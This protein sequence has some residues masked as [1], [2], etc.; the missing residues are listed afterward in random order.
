MAR[1]GVIVRLMENALLTV[2]SLSAIIVLG[3][4]MAR[5]FTLPTGFTD[6]ISK[7]VFNI[8]VP[9]AIFYAFAQAEFDPSLLMLV[10]LGFVCCF[11]PWFVAT[12]VSWREEY[13]RRVLLMTNISGYNIGNF[14]L[15]FAQ[16]FFPS[17]TIVALCLFDAGNSI[18]I[19]GGIYPFSSVILEKGKS[20]NERM[21]LALK[22][23]F[24]SVPFDLY[25]VLVILAA[26][27][28]TIPYQLV[29]LVE[30]FAH[31]NAFLAMF[32]IG[33]MV[34]FSIDLNKLGQLVRLVGLRLILSTILSATVFFLLPFDLT[35]RIVIASLLWAPS[36]GLGPVFTMWLKGDVG[37]AGFSNVVTVVVGVIAMTVLAVIIT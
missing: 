12:I 30:P 2:V 20:Y 18:M 21:K 32:L 16:A 7:I 27:G 1:I 22:R 35:M 10:P 3:F 14:V 19:N 23:L 11:I 8:T 26:A 36:A 24:K 28:V 37:L 29:I 9:C 34:N 25:V 33:L 13:E 15:P 4:V 17:S 5:M 31:A 6:I